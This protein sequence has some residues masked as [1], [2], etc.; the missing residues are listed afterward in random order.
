MFWSSCIWYCVNCC[1]W[2]NARWSQ[3]GFQHSDECNLSLLVLANRSLIITEE[4]L[5][6]FDFSQ[7]ISSSLSGHCVILKASSSGSNQ[8]FLLLL[9]FSLGPIPRGLARNTI[10]SYSWV[11]GSLKPYFCL[12][13]ST[14]ISAR[15]VDPDF[16]L[17]C[18]PRCSP[19]LSTP[20]SAW[21]V[22]PY[23][24]WG[25]STPIF[26]W[27]FFLPGL[28][29]PISAWVSQP[30]TPCQPEKQE[31]LKTQLTPNTKFHA[32]PSVGPNMYYYCSQ[33]L[34]IW[35]NA[36]IVFHLTSHYTSPYRMAFFFS[37]L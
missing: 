16:C 15:S 10:V 28:S 24:C 23:F 19:S 22:D 4:A 27:S 34:W 33:R 13:L 21:S 6:Y 35:S 9:C 37:F 30:W 2:W 31:V 5:C 32:L 12:G 3:I 1:T 17:I 29:T 18:R 36:V 25:L 8:S 14:L 20:I 26:A 7:Y 11:T